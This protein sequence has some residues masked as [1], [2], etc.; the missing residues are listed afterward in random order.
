MLPDTETGN[1]SLTYGAVTAESV[2][3]PESTAAARSRVFCMPI[4]AA[5]DNPGEP[6]LWSAAV[7]ALASGVDVASSNTGIAVLGR[8]DPDQAR[9]FAISAGNVE[10][11]QA[12][13]RAACDSSGIE[14]PA[15]AWNALTVGAHTELTGAP[16]DPSFDGWSALASEGDIS[17]FSCTS[18]PFATRTWPVKPDICMEGGNVLTDGVKD[19]DDCHPLLSLRTTDTRNDLSLG[20]VNAT[21]A[22]TAQAARLAAL[23]MVGYPSYWPETIRGLL[24]HAA[25]WTPLMRSQIDGAKGR[26]GKLGLGAKPVCVRIPGAGDDPPE[27]QP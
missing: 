21:S 14:D 12:D 25:E 26:A 7:D 17:P 13:Y 8:P 1:D 2:A 23:A 27:A 6:T 3:L 15:H 16:Q 10:R 19:F 11:L 9:L 24:S 4:T 22:A 18:L 5:P 20:S